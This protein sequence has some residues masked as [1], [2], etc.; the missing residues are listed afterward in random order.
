MLI[1]QVVHKMKI[2]RL[3]PLLLLFIVGCSPGRH[4]GHIIIHDP[5]HYEVV[6]DVPMS[7]EFEQ[8]DIKVKASSLKGSFFEDIL[9]FLLLK[10]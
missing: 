6:F 2:K 4:S 1:I 7:M 3:L 10:R 5:N 8:G 9:K